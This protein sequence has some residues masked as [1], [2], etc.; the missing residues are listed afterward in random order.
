MSEGVLGVPCVRM[1][2]VV[3]SSRGS[4]TDG[5]RTQEPRRPTGRRRPDTAADDTGHRGG[6]ARLARYR[7]D[8]DSSN[9]NHSYPRCNLRPRESAGAAHMRRPEG[10]FPLRRPI[11]RRPR[12]RTRPQ[13]RSKAGRQLSRGAMVPEWP[14]GADACTHTQGANHQ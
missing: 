9:M 10:T 4:T 6:R 7:F 8:L 1:V 11:D 5:A 12:A 13:T 2:R 14:V 3:R